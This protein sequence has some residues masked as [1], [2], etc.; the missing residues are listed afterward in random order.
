MTAYATLATIARTKL[1]GLNA[2]RLASLAD[3]STPDDLDSAGALFLTRHRNTIVEALDNAVEDL[4]A[5]MDD[6][7]IVMAIEDALHEA[8]DGAPSVYTHELFKQFTDL[9]VW[10]EDISDY[11]GED[12]DMTKRAT[13]ALYV[14]A[15]RLSRVLVE[16]Y[17]E[18]IDEAEEMLATLTL[19]KVIQQAR[20]DVDGNAVVVYFLEVG[21]KLV[22]RYAEDDEVVIYSQTDERLKRF[23]SIADAEAGMVALLRA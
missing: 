1:D 4:D 21:G 17:A 6:T 5:T 22:Y 7:E 10:D 18:A 15:D 2:Y 14:A 13:L 12:D 19:H 9:C 20:V 3:V 8:A 11:I 16:A 23:D